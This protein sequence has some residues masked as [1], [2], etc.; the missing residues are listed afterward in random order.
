MFEHKP[1]PWPQVNPI[2][3]EAASITMVTVPNNR[4]AV[5]LLSLDVAKDI[6]NAG[7]L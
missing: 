5:L 3:H 6:R 7:A 4:E 1:L 2:H